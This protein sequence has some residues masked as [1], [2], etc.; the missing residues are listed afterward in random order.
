MITLRNYEVLDIL[1]A[2][3]ETEEAF[4]R[5]AG[6][7]SGFPECCIEYFIWRCDQMENK[8]ITVPRLV[9]DSHH[10]VCPTC[11]EKHMDGR[12]PLKYYTCE[13]CGWSQLFVKDCMICSSNILK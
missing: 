9:E 10:I 8:G 6:K 7:L 5:E 12:K 1:K 2:R 13:V 4:Y 11:A 3:N